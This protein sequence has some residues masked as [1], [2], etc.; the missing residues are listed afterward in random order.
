M[1]PDTT[2]T[3][4]IKFVTQAALGWVVLIAI[5]VTSVSYGGVEP[6]T[7]SLLAFFCLF[8]FA[9]Q[10]ALDIFDDLPK[11]V[12]KLT[13]VG[14]ILFVVLV[15]I[16]FQTQ[17][18]D[19][20]VSLHSAWENV[21]SASPS[22]SLNPISGYHALLR[23]LLYF[24]VFWIILRSANDPD[25]ALVFLK[26]IAFWSSAM[27]IYGLWAA[28]TGSNPLTG[29]E[30][31]TVTG[32]FINRNSYA[33]Y[34]MIGLIA[35][36]GVYFREVTKAAAGSEIR[37][38]LRDFLE[39]FFSQGWLFL[40][41]FILCFAAL[42][43][44]Q[45]RAGFAAAGIALLVFFYLHMKRR[46]FDQRFALST[47][48]VISIF[49][50][51]TLSLGVL[52]RIVSLDQEA[53]RFIVYPRILDAIMEQPLLG[54]GL[55]AFQDSF[56]AYVPIEASR[57]EW[58]F[59]HSSYL[60]N[61]YEMG[62][63][64]AALFYFALGLFFVSMLRGNLKRE[65]NRAFSNVALA[66]FAGCAFHS[67]FDFSLQIPSVTLLFVTVMAIG[68]AQAQPSKRSSRRS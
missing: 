44:S 10:L 47:A 37:L 20:P 13:T 29:E 5:L 42:L 49:L 64:A 57:A 53:L 40:V 50:V 16:A 46:F 67:L 45:S 19:L 61:I 21:P 63:P 65:R 54:Y 38:I 23:L 39:S 33:T 68:W 66:V 15:W 26:V 55:G 8:L 36:L 18:I 9:V 27:A 17:P 25:R 35:N 56:R 30:K 1:G 7:W 34:A 51:A 31:R 14:S 3:S 59:A 2:L 4:K 22:I 48:L 62:I 28:A 60:E 11:S 12:T 32:T 6:L 43:A 41:G 52:T 58:F 24:F